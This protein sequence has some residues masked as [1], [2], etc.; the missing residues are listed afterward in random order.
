MHHYNQ[1][2]YNRSLSRK[3]SPHSKNNKIKLEKSSNA[4]LEKV[5]ERVLRKVDKLYKRK[6]DGG[7]T[8]DSRLSRIP[9]ESSNLESQRWRGHSKT[10]QFTPESH[11]RQST[12]NAKK[13]CTNVY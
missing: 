12:F 2:L 11:Y 9:T 6:S 8:A 10:S 13:K 1:S 4:S 3:L 5:R 7:Q